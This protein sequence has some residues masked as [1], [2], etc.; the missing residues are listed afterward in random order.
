MSHRCVGAVGFDVELS[1]TRSPVED[2]A[3]PVCAARFLGE[4][5]VGKIPFF[6]GGVVGGIP[7]FVGGVF[8]DN[9]AAKAG[10]RA[11]TFK[12]F[13]KTA[14]VAGFDPADMHDVGDVHDVGAAHL[15]FVLV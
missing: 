14:T 5:G 12:P 10:A 6:V 4:G 1:A 8:F 13:A 2:E 9:R 7:V 3:P 15:T 11:L